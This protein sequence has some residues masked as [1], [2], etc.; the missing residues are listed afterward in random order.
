MPTK[1]P[2]RTLKNSTPTI[3]FGRF[4]RIDDS[5]EAPILRNGVRVG[6]IFALCG[7]LKD[8]EHAREYEILGFGRY[9]KAIPSVGF[10][11]NGDPAHAL[12]QAKRSARERI[13][14][15]DGKSVTD[16]RVTHVRDVGSNGSALLRFSPPLEGHAYAVASVSKTHDRGLEVM[17]FPANADGRT[18]DSVDLG[19]WIGRD[20]EPL[21]RWLGYRVVNS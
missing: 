15:A 1:K 13:L 10:K 14:R 2:R 19:S 21:V 5:L 4:D 17:L 3:S 7:R 8:W 20:Y 6:T 18:T 9:E 11:S 12:E 16:K